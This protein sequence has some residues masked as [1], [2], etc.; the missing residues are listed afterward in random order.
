MINLDV[1]TRDA[2]IGYL[3]DWG[4]IIDNDKNCIFHCQDAFCMYCVSNRYLQQ[5][6][7]SA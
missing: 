4:L 5:R 6:I 7:N 1:Y 2:N 3:E